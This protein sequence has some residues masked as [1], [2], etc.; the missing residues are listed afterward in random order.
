MDRLGSGLLLTTPADRQEDS[1]GPADTPT[2]G[3]DP[4]HGGGKPGF[5]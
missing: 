2:G 1:Q 3:R 4:R 5:P